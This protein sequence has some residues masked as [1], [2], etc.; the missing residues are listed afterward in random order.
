MIAL[1]NWHHPEIFFIRPCWIKGF[2]GGSRTYGTWISLLCSA[3]VLLEE[4][5]SKLVRL[6]G[7]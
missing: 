6:Y 7:F 1:L 3:T 5:I 4:S 2:T